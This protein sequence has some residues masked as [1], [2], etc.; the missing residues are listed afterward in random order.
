M[1]DYQDRRETL[2]LK[3]R[4]AK[5]GV[6]PFWIADMDYR[7]PDCIR[8]ALREAIEEPLGYAMNPEGYLP[9]FLEWERK[10]QGYEVKPEWVEFAPG[11]VP[12]MHWLI[13][14]FTKKGDA[15]IITPPVYVSFIEAIEYNERKRID[16]DLVWDGKRWQIDFADFEQKIIDNDVKAFILCNPH[17]PTGNVWTGEELKRLL[18]ICQ[19]HHVYVI[20]DEIHQDLYDPALG[21]KK[22]TAATVGDYDDILFTLT[23]ASKSFNLGGVQNAF[24]IIPDEEN[25][26]KFAKY[27]KVLGFRGGNTLG[28][29][30]TEAAFAKG[31][32]WLDGA[33][34]DIY[35]NEKILRDILLEAFPDLPMAKLEG[36]YLVWIDLSGWFR[37]EGEVRSF[38]EEIRILPS[39][40]EE[41]GGKR[42][43]S[44]I[45]FNI[46]TSP[47]NVREGV[48]RLV[49]GLKKRN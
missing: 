43:G 44:F 27:R 26:K 47:E 42:Y 32:E 39:F 2:S 40:G 37:N 11:V 38:C 24:A 41:F 17:N 29:V 23:A 9:A 30:A 1:A 12:A 33:I 21:R 14:I 20:V 7:S 36:T 25:R 6:L 10:Y 8:E 18:D 16:S 19:K 3:W 13:D 49:E 35:A 22:V 5:E 15:V 45:R 46:A 28:Y 34:R 31:R 4:R 48:K